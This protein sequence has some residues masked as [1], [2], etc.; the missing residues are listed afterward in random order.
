MI[1]NFI[2]SDKYNVEFVVPYAQCNEY[3][4][5]ER[6]TPKHEL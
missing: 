2:M 1:S 6:I 4:S 5:P 3:F